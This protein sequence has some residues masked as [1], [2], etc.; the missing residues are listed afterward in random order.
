MTASKTGLG[1]KVS[2]HAGYARPSQDDM[3]LHGH[4][5]VQVIGADGTVKQEIPFDNV[6]TE[7]GDQR[8]GEAGAGLGAP[9]AAPTGM[10][11]GTG[12]TAPAKTGVG[13]AIVT[14][15][16]GSAK[17]FDSTPA[18]ALD[19]GVRQITYVTTW[20]AGE[21]TADGI[22]EVVVMNQAVATDAAAPAANTLSRALLSPTVNKAAGD[23][24]AVTYRHRIGTV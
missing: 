16:A 11:L 17:A 6:I 5:V 4:G 7:V 15:I 20:A 8:Y 21:A 13:S 10:Q 22:S 19:T 23:S 18:S 9:P 1:D 2:A 14:Y 12:T 3:G 24:L